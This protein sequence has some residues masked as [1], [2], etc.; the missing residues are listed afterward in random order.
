[1]LPGTT[2]DFQNMTAVNE[3]VLQN[4]ENNLLV[5]FAGFGKG[6]VEHGVKTKQPGW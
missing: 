6:F 5:L 3:L 1:M 4:I 2:A